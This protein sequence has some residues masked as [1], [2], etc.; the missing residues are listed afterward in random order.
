M[1]TITPLKTTKDFFDT[2]TN[3]YEKKAPSQKKD[4]KNNLCNMNMERDETIASFFTN[5]LPMRDQITSI[6]LETD[7]NDLLQTV[8]DGL[9]S[10]WENFLVAV[11]GREEKSNFEYF[12][13]TAS[14]KKGTS[15]KNL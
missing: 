1:S 13:V 10:S 8:I 11:N 14:K 7:D 5:N 12:G 2:L 4:L 15:I 9:P 3:I 6:G